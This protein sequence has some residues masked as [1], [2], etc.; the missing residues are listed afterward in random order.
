ML[1]QST[2][3]AQNKGNHW[4]IDSGCSSHII[5]EQIKFLTL[6]ELNEGI[7]TFGDNIAAK[8]VGK[9][10]LSLDNG[11]T[12]TENVLYVEGLEYNLLSVI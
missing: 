4:Y 7:V 9:G 2:L 6:K 1:V 12:K 5:G 8:I 3:H 10:T 11:K